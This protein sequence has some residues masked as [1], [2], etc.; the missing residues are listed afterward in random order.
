MSRETNGESGVRCMEHRIKENQK[1]LTQKVFSGL[2][3]GVRGLSG[4]LDLRDW[5][6][7]EKSNF[8][9]AIHCKPR[10][11]DAR[12][13][14]E[15]A[16][17]I[18]FYLDDENRIWCRL[19]VRKTP[20]DTLC[21]SKCKL[22][23]VIVLADPKGNLSCCIPGHDKQTMETFVR[24]AADYLEGHPRPPWPANPVLTGQVGA[25]CVK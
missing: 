18:Q 9:F 11:G 15:F 16:K 10:P 23:Q 19:L 2:L 14:Y 5:V 13:P 4:N 22:F 7:D 20:S 12:N 8:I 25:S 1:S 21:Y 3:R 24:G 6:L 17:G